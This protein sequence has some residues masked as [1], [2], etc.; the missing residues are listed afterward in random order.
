MDVNN[1]DVILHQDG[2]YARV[3]GTAQF[4]ARFSILG[5]HDFCLLSNLQ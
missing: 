4:Q 2:G 1:R 5:I 3:F